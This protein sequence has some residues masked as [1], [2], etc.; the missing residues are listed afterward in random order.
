MPCYAIEDLIPVVDPTA[1]VHPDAILIGDVIVGPRCYVGA[2]AVLR[3]DFGRIVLKAGSNLQDNC[4]M[5]SFPGQDCVVEADGHV[6]HGATL[7]GCTVGANALVGMHSVVMDGAVIGANSFV[8]AC[9]FVKA[10]FD[11]PEQVLLIGNPAAVKRPLSDDE[12]SWKRRGTGE[13]QTL[14]ERSL[15]SHRTIEPLTQ[16]QPQRPRFVA[17]NHKPK[18]S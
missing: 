5:H 15:A 17:S 11:C 14:T 18:G 1:F 13:Y 8:G 2:G 10:G 9:S 16:V 7:H 4:V 12:V 6:G 3:G